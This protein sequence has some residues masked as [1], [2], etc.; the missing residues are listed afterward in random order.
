M[1]A[2]Q[3]VFEEGVRSFEILKTPNE[4]RWRR[5]TA[6]LAEEDFPFSDFLTEDFKKEDFENVSDQNLVDDEN[7]SDKN[8]A[9]DTE[10]INDDNNSEKKSEGTDQ[11]DDDNDSLVLIMTRWNHTA[12]NVETGVAKRLIITRDKRA[13]LK[14]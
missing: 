2:I 12:C 9:E 14:R 13:S 6:S 4:T 10:Q 11:V 1:E 3:T 5:V 8:F 7:N